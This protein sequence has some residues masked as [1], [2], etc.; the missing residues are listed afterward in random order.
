MRWGAEKGHRMSVGDPW[1]AKRSVGGDLMEETVATSESSRIEVIRRRTSGILTW[2]LEQPTLVLIWLHSGFSRAHL[3]IDR[4]SVDVPISRHASL[5]L[6]ASNANVRGEFETQ[7]DTAYSMAFLDAGSLDREANFKNSVFTFADDRIASGFA[8]VSR[9]AS[10]TDPMYSLLLEGWSLQTISRLGT[11][12]ILQPSNTE[13]SGRLT[14]SRF[15][16][17]RQ[18]IE[19]SYSMPLSVSLLAEVAGYSPRHFARAFRNTSGK[20][21]LS[22]IMDLRIEHAKRL[23]LRGELSMS[24]V[25][26]ACGFGQS[27]WLSNVF[28]RKTG[29]TPTEYFRQSS[30]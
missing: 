1:A 12:S 3:R 11:L 28:R 30:T 5:G 20:T 24:E 22:Y 18:F 4:R 6:I 19:A 27:Q 2:E 26:V 17:V 15:D 8:E 9:E 14:A 10:R 23:I 21:P 13:K 25:A 29:L 16:E 7:P